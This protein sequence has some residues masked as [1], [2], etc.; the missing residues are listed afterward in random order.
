MKVLLFSAISFA[1]CLLAV[2]NIEDKGPTPTLC[3]FAA[4][5]SLVV[6]FTV[7]F[8]IVKQ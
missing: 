8:K 4:I 2:V 5:I 3:F 6:A 7:R 1:F